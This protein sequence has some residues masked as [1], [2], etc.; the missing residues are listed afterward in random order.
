MWGRTP[1]YALQPHDLEHMSPMIARLGSQAWKQP[2]P[3]GPRAIQGRL[4]MCLIRH[5]GETETGFGELY[6]IISATTDFTFILLYKPHN[7]STS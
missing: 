2:M 1:S 6:S 3:H 7:S 4:K 5:E